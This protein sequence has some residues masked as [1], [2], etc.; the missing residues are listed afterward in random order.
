MLFIHVNPAPL[1]ETEQVHP[2]ENGTVQLPAG[3]HGFEVGSTHWLLQQTPA[4][5]SSV[6]LHGPLLHLDDDVE[7]VVG[8]PV[9]ETAVVI[10]DVVT[11]TD[12]VNDDVAADDVVIDDVVIDD[13][14]D[15]EVV[16][17]TVVIPDV[18][19][20]TVVTGPIGVGVGVGVGHFPG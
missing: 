8:V 3:A 7:P 17:E 20:D 18:V 14:V 6:V 16:T 13:V 1:H 15:D 4:R 12:V 11:D 10:T 19:I 5:Q 9:T 2:S